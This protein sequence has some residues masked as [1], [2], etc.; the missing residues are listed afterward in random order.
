MTSL[1]AVRVRHY[2][3][4]RLRAADLQADAAHA[5]SMRQLHVRTLHDTWGVA[6]GLEVY[7]E[8]STFLVG[9][10]LAYDRLGREIVVLQPLAAPPLSGDDGD[11]VYA[12][13][14]RLSPTGQ[15][16]LQWHLAGDVRLGVEVPLVA[17]PI[18]AGAV[19]LNAV[20]FN[21]RPYAQPLTRPH[22]AYGL[23]PR[24]QRWR[25]WRKGGGEREIGF[26]LRVDTTAAGFVGMPFY[27]AS[28]QLSSNSLFVGPSNATQVQMYVFGSLANATR[29]GFTY[30]V[31]FAGP[32]PTPAAGAAPPPSVQDVF[33][34]FN[35]GNLPFQVVWTGIE[36]VDAFVPGDL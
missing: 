22:I 10:G 21:V 5:T 26:G 35:A 18:S 31:V 36:P 11:G 8:G 30:R 20:N 15:P 28:L 29:T 12:L 33:K 17:V 32:P 4:E 7:L 1:R 34:R 27:V 25:V 24:E 13:V 3:G 6:L 23:T 16:E 2:Q 14:A 19:D 9:R